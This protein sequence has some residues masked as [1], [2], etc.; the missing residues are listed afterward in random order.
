MKKTNKK[1]NHFGQGLALGASLVTAIAGGIFLYGPNGKNN[2][3]QIKTW[4]LKAKA[5]VLDELAKMKEVSQ[6]KYELVVDKVAN[7]YGKL[8]QV[9]E[10][11]A[12]AL[13][14]ELKRHWKGVVS[15][16]KARQKK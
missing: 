9:G 3:K 8:K 7:K 14:K 2:R 1:T 4:S 16:I 6:D 5:E 15:E 13:A 11:E 10:G 12:L